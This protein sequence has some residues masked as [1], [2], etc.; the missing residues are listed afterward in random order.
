MSAKCWERSGRLIFYIRQPGKSSVR[1]WQ[2]K[3]LK[4]ADHWLGAS[5]PRGQQ[6]HRP[7][8]GTCL[9]GRRKQVWRSE[10]GRTVE[11][12]VR[13]KMGP[14][15]EGLRSHSETPCFQLNTMWNHWRILSTWETGPV[16][17]LRADWRKDKSRS[18]ATIKQTVQGR[19][20]SASDPGGS[21][22]DGGGKGQILDILWRKWQ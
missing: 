13:H 5:R 7:E 19:D 20:P 22:G 4:E 21:S 12:E 14:D 11:N 6:V 10:V 2:S 9:W 1:K 18:R 8:V 17:L 3:N 15:L 16:W